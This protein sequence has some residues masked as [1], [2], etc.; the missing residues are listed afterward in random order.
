MIGL[1]TL[2]RNALHGLIARDREVLQ[3][4]QRDQQAIQAEWYEVLAAIE[5]ALGLPFG[6]IGATYTLDLATLTVVPVLAPDG[7]TPAEREGA[8]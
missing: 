2:H 5:T 8:A 7:V 3:V 1:S 6:A 4:F